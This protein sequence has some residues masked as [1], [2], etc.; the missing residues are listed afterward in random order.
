MKMIAQVRVH[1]D[2]L[3]RLRFMVRGR[4]RVMASP[5]CS[6]TRIFLS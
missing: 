3:V 5:V 2:C 4:V 1:M 6:I